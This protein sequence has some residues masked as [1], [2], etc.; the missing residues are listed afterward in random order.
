ML[1]KPALESLNLDD[2]F[3][4]PHVSERQSRKVETNWTLRS[5]NIMKMLRKELEFVGKVSPRWAHGSDIRFLS[6]T[7]IT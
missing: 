2:L 1:D 7:G 6:D 4:T 3:L 5:L